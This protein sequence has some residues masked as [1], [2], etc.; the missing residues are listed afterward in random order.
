[1]NSSNQGRISLANFLFVLVEVFAILS[2]VWFYGLEQMSGLFHLVP[3]IAVGFAIHS[4]LPIRFRPGFFLILSCVG[5]IAVVPPP[6]GIAIIAIGVVLIL[7]AHLP[8]AMWIRVGIIVATGV[9]LSL[10]RTGLVEPGW[11]SLG[12][13]VIPVVGS[14]FMFRMIIYLHDM[15]HEKD[16]PPWPQRVSYFFML[17]NVCFLLF[18]VVDYQTYKRKYYDEEAFD[19]YSKGAWWMFRGVTHLLLYR[20]I[21]INFVPSSAEVE[22]IWGVAHAFVATYLLYL[23]ISGQFHLIA[24]IMCLFGH[25]FLETNHLYYLASSASDYW[26]R[27]NIYWKDFMTKIFYNHAFVRFKKAGVQTAVMLSMVYVFVITWAL[28][29]YQW[30]W[31]KGTFPVAP[32]DLV[33]WGSFMV[34]AMSGVY[35]EMKRPRRRAEASVTYYSCVGHAVKVM[36]TFATIS[37]LWSLWSSANLAAFGALL[38]K[39]AQSSPVE[40]LLFAAL[41]VGLILAGALVRF[42]RLTYADSQIFNL[43]R[44]GQRLWWY[45]VTASFVLL[46]ISVS[47]IESVLPDTPRKIVAAARSDRLNRVDEEILEAGYYETLL[48]PTDFLKSLWVNNTQRPPGWNTHLLDEGVAIVAKD[49]LMHRLTPSASINW[50]DARFSTN[51]WG[52][53]DQEYEKTKPDGVVRVALLGSSKEMGWGVGDN[54]TFEGIVERELNSENPEDRLELLN[55]SVHGYT[56]IQ[57]TRVIELGLLNEFDVDALILCTNALWA[58]KVGESLHRL[59]R[60]GIPTGYPKLETITTEAGLGKT[61]RYLARQVDFD[62]EAGQVLNWAFSRIKQVADS[63]GV[64]VYVAFIPSINRDPDW[65]V[66]MREAANSYG[67]GFININDAYNDEDENDLRVAPWDSHPNERAHAL[68][69]RAFKPQMKIIVEGLRSDSV[70]TN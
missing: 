35:F 29:S 3:L 14:F 9:A 53:R 54:S 50:R 32:K 33:F 42:V 58:D 52:M 21:Y 56:E 67:F 20:I 61:D 68:I 19:I 36:G 46:A 47:G 31:L 65:L 44:K 55:F 4:F 43:Q 26:R 1:M 23:R 5:I 37:F 8:V 45:P 6:N 48:E 70:A 59:R 13:L 49:V 51:S 11:T 63:A 66:T 41:V 30:L 64:P 17:P 28:H 2:V 15:R 24:G 16:P 10:I 27:I 7:V 38:A 69:A 39:T 12:S 40:Y 18:P 62:E 34:L 22:G 25:N 60:D 57:Y